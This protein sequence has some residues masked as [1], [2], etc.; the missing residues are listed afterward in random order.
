[1]GIAEQR[2]S[3][4]CL[5]V[6][7]FSKPGIGFTRRGS[8]RQ[9]MVDGNFSP[10]AARRAGMSASEGEDQ[11]CEQPRTKVRH[12]AKKISNTNSPA[13]AMP[14]PTL[15]D[16]KIG[17]DGP[18]VFAIADSIIVHAKRGR[19]NWTSIHI[20]AAPNKNRS[21]GCRP[22]DPDQGAD[23]NSMADAPCGARSIAAPGHQEPKLRLVVSE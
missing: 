17:I 2:A 5:S 12:N 6:T 15:P 19:T 8:S 10:R 1:M 20:R 13:R 21:A 23:Q 7:H 18:L 14:G 11:S 9:V 16:I 3:H 4:N 22:S